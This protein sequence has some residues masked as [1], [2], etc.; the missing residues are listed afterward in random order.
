VADELDELGAG[1]E[2]PLRRERVPTEEEPEADGHRRLRRLLGGACLLLGIAVVVAAVLTTS[3][4]RGTDHADGKSGDTT[5]TV[6][7]GSDGTKTSVESATSTA[8]DA[9][10]QWPAA[11]GGRPPAF[12]K[13]GDPAPTDPGDLPDGFYVWTDF[14]GWH[15]WLVG[16]G[17][18]DRLTLTSD[19][20]ITKATPVGGP[21]DVQ[22]QGNVFTLQ[23]GSATER[24]V[25]VDFNPGYFARNMIVAV[26]GAQPTFVGAKATKVPQ[27]WAMRLEPR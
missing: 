4:D 11:T 20:A 26:D 5:T 3:D 18:D 24:V 25:G 1:D 8:A 17:A 15:G 21:V 9:K 2:A 6:A 19:N 10:P 27:I 13:T 23:R 12:G 7:G 16:G 14:D 22:L